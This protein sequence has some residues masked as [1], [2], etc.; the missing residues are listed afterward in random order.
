MNN[1]NFG[2]INFDSKDNNYLNYNSLCKFLGNYIKI[3]N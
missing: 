1:I 3:I 2:Y